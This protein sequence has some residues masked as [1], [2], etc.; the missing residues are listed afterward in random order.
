MAKLSEKQ[1]ELLRGKN[2]GTVTTL[3][4]D[5]SPRSVSPSATMSSAD[6]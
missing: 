4:K 3:R 1:A 2:W 5:G 6:R